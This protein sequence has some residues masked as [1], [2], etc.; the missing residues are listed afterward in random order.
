MALRIENPCPGCGLILLYGCLFD[1]MD[2]AQEYGPIL[3]LHRDA[4]PETAKAGCIGISSLW[5]AEICRELY[6]CPR[7]KTDPIFDI[8]NERTGADVTH[9]PSES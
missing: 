5:M 1:A 8:P 2:R 9:S 3:G 7:C 4:R 6:R